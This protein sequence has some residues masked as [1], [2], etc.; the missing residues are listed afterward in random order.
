MPSGGEGTNYGT[1]PPSTT[2]D[3][4]QPNGSLLSV[5][6][7]V[8][9]YIEQSMIYKQINKSYSYRDTRWPANQEAAKQEIPIFVCPSDA[10]VSFRDPEGYGRADYFAT[11]YTDIDPDT[12]LRNKPT[13][14]DG[15]LCVPAAPMSAISD[16]T[17]NTI[18]IIEDAGRIHQSL[19][20]PG[21]A[22][23]SISTYDD[24]TCTSGNGD[25]TDC[26]GTGNKRG[27][28]ARWADQDAT[29]SGVSGPPNAV[30]TW[31]SFINQNATPTGGPVDCP[32]SQNNCG[33]NDEP[34][35]FHPGG[36]NAVFADG[37]VRF[38][39]ENIDA[40]TMRGLVTRAEAIAVPLPE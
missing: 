27:V 4:L 11:V 29:G 31:S 12:G 37:S 10:F 33:L 30:A 22:G 18:M 39:G 19:K 23:G 35:S 7:Q 1:N 5:F 32:W 38:L 17:S 14:A 9:P 28:A 3:D 25:A 6:G 36:C 26:A 2:F 16:G 21:G 40:R 13:R 24:P 15:A 8:L 34:F 20:F